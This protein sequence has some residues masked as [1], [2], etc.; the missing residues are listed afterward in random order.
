MHAI[1]AVSFLNGATLG[2]LLPFVAVLLAERGASPGAIGAL[3]ATASVAFVL[4]V[5]GWGHIGD[6]VLGR[7]RTLALSAFGAAAAI[8]IAGS[9][10]PAAIASAAFVGFYALYSAW[11]P[12]ADALAV[13]ALTDHSR[14]YGRIRVIMS[15]A[16]ATASLVAG[17][18]YDMT[19][20]GASFLLCALLATALG[21]AALFAPDVARADLDAVARGSRRRGSFAVALRIQPRLWAVLVAILLVHIGMAATYTFLPLRMVDLGASSREIAL[22]VSVSAFVE[23]PAMLVVGELAARVGIRFV[24]A[25]SVLIYAGVFAALMVIHEP[26]L[27]IL[28]RAATG[29]AFAGLW[30]GNV[31]TMAVLLP[32]RLQGTGQGLYQVTG[33]GLAAV[34]ANVGGGILYERIGATALFGAATVL[35]L[36]ALVITLVAFPRAGERVAREEDFDRPLPLSPTSA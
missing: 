18:V 20:Y 34:V 8:L 36:L 21:V 7:R 5:P 23:I 19:G 13:N 1:R 28:V 3:L 12:L 32:P 27:I 29:F 6:A 17:L 22:L 35:A 24:V 15:F 2:V 33:Y 4:S 31:L 26:D 16:F 10:I 30:V 11:A 14:Q 25:C 9:P